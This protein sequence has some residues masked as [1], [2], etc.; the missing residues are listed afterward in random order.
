MKQEDDVERHNRHE[1]KQTKKIETKNALGS[2]QVVRK[3]L[4][5]RTRR[6]TGSRSVS[7][8]GEGSKLKLGGFRTIQKVKKEK[9]GKYR[10]GKMKRP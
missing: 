6:P 3:K 4:S 1:R 10:D 5:K 7:E 8:M 2:Y 9:E